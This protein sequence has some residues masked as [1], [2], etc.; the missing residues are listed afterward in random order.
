VLGGDEVEDLGCWNAETIRETIE[1]QWEGVMKVLSA[2]I[3]F[4]VTPCFAQNYV[5]GG[6]PAAATNA[7]FHASAGYTY[8][9]L[10]TPSQPTVGLNGIDAMVLSSHSALGLM[11]DTCYARMGDV[12]APDTVPMSLVF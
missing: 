5:T 3:L 2:C 6:A 12:F 8:V 10:N 7:V 4:L 11:A 9:A 1:R